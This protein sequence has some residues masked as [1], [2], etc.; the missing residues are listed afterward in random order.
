MV[1]ASVPEPPP[2]QQHP[3]SGALSSFFHLGLEIQVNELVWHGLSCHF[4]LSKHL[5]GKF[6]S[7]NDLKENCFGCLQVTEPTPLELH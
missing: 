3:P 4:S 5:I 7:I 1:E 6:C 2:S